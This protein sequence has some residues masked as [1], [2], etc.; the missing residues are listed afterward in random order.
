[1]S[2]LVSGSLPVSGGAAS[3]R[4]EAQ[5]GEVRSSAGAGGLAHGLEGVDDDTVVGDLRLAAVIDHQPRRLFLRAGEA[6]AVEPHQIDGRDPPALRPDV[7]HEA[8]F[9]LE[10][11]DGR[12]GRPEDEGEDPLVEGDPRLARGEPRLRARVA[13]AARADVPPPEPEQ[14]FEA[15]AAAAI[16]V[17]IGRAAR[18]DHRH[19]HRHEEREVADQRGDDRDLEQE[20]ERLP[21]LASDRR[22]PLAPGDRVTPRERGVELIQ[23]L[24]AL[25][26]AEVAAVLLEQQGQGALRLHLGKPGG[27]DG[28]GA[29]ELA[30][31]PAQRLLHEGGRTFRRVFLALDGRFGCQLRHLL[32]EL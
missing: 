24:A 13:V 30:A 12:R 25:G 7:G 21:E 17:A 6:P 14:A 22:A 3:S 4:S 1:M 18:E 9:V 15:E 2:A 5:R 19:H 8:L 20:G 16:V 27:D 10:R 11:V 23:Q 31:A 32:T 26:G 29:R 28:I